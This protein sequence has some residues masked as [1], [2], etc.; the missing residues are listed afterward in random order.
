[1]LGFKVLH[2]YLYNTLV[3]KKVLPKYIILLSTSVMHKMSKSRNIQNDK[4]LVRSQK[5]QHLTVKTFYICNYVN[6]TTYITFNKNI[7]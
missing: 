1:M 4:K 3:L 2:M 5:K 7:T 6:I